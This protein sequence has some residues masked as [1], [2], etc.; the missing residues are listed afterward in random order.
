MHYP[1]A[2]VTRNISVATMYGDIVSIIRTN[3]GEIVKTARFK[4]KGKENYIEHLGGIN[5]TLVND[6]P[7]AFGE[8]TMDL[9]SMGKIASMI[10]PSDSEP[11]FT[12]PVFL[13]GE[14]ETKKFKTEDAIARVLSELNSE[15]LSS[16]EA[17]NGL[18]DNSNHFLLNDGETTF[19]RTFISYD[20]NGNEMISNLD[21]GIE[22]DQ[23]IF[24]RRETTKFVIDNSKL[25]EPQNRPPVFTGEYTDMPLD[26]LREIYEATVFSAEI[27]WGSHKAYVP[28]YQL[29]FPFKHYFDKQIDNEYEEKGGSS[30]YVMIENIRYRVMDREVTYATELTYDIE[31]KDYKLSITQIIDWVKLD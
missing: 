10:I 11:K 28:R 29:Y 25:T 16:A 30:K 6:D 8:R 27:K 13:S 7:I 4:D 2:F 19:A 15:K 9:P 14:I 23:P 17:K 22:N 26:V 21:S 31:Y 12:P 5:L 18:I 24:A 20:Y 1:Y 3:T